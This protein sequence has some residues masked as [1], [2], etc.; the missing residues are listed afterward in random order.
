M[1]ELFGY[2]AIILMGMTLGVIGAGGS[3][4]TVPILVY[5]FKAAGR[6]ALAAGEG[7]IV[8]AITGMVGAG[9]GFLIVPALVWMLGLPMKSAVTTSLM[10]I[11]LKSL[12]GFAGDLQG[13]QEMDWLFLLTLFGL[14]AVGILAGSAIAQRLPAG[15]LQR[16]FGWF[17][18]CTGVFTI[19]RELSR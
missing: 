14:S 4:L 13:P 18:L 6:V 10:I 8:G 1:S 3:I 15:R 5:L 19:V 16:G 9:G 12:I 7:L 11:A 17:V 2:L